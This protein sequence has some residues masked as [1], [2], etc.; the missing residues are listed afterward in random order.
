MANESEYPQHESSGPDYGQAGQRPND[1]AQSPHEQWSP[2]GQQ[3]SP[4]D[5]APAS[6][7]QPYGQG[8]YGQGQ[9]G[10][11]PQYGQAP[12]GQPTYDQPQYGQQAY[13]Q[14]GYGQPQYSQHQYSQPQYG[15]QSYGQA[16]Y[17]Q[18]PPTGGAASWNTADPGPSAPQ[19]GWRP[20][21]AAGLFPLRPL[22][23]GDIFGA[24]F[25]LLRFSPAASFGGVYLLQFFGTVLAA[26]GPITVLLANIDV[27]TLNSSSDVWTDEHTQL[28]IW[29][30][31]S[32][33]P[34]ILVTLL[35]T[36]ASQAVVAQV[37]AKAAIG[38]RITLG[39]ALSRAT[40]RLL[41]LLGYL[42]L[43]SLIN[44]VVVGV[45]VGLPMWWLF[46]A[47]FDRTS[48]IGPIALLLLSLLLVACA[49]VF[50]NT[51]F[52]FGV[53]VVILE[54]AGP[55]QAIRRSWTL[56]NNLFWRTFG[57]SLLVSMV[58]S[59]ATGF[60]SQIAVMIFG[61]I[62]QVALPFGG[63]SSRDMAIWFGIVIGVL[64]S[65]ISAIFTAVY[66]VLISG[67]SVILYADARMRKEGLNIPL[68]HAADELT[69]DP[70]ADPDPWSEH[71]GKT[72]SQPTPGW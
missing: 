61:L 18:F 40:K 65:L 14:G 36:T 47:I 55:I 34:S 3:P 54:K 26:V 70:S 42:V 58:V 27:P 44:F 69:S 38:Q 21:A 17:G 12:Y 33:I 5:Q 60:A 52:L 53:S 25:R 4:D 59:M 16:P 66:T 7:Q 31:L 30:L 64:V 23:F 6:G 8:G 29:M 10:G 50:L 72:A 67:N 43:I 11:Q 24:T 15:Q 46:A 56:T 68:Q 41:P 35:M 71:I 51:K 2:A 39:A 19:P 22:T 63:E 62:A 20:A 9:Y 37:T 13:G 48:P 1:A 28:L 45:L 57:I 49:T 32:L